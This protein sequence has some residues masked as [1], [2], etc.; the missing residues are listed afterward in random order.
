MTING[1]KI[2]DNLTEQ[3][4]ENLKK[5]GALNFQSAGQ[6]RKSK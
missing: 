6:T 5:Y 3:Q 4:I 1:R 2:K